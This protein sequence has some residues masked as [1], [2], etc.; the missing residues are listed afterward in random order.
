MKDLIVRSQC[1]IQKLIRMVI[2]FKYQIVL[3]KW[4]Q[5]TKQKLK[6]ITKP[7]FFT[8]ED[9][10]TGKMTV[11]ID[12]ETTQHPKNEEFYEDF[13]KIVQGDYNN[14]CNVLLAREKEKKEFKDKSRKKFEDDDRMETNGDIDAKDHNIFSFVSLIKPKRFI[15]NYADSLK[16]YKKYIIFFSM[17]FY[18][19][20]PLF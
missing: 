14:W 8:F 1:L 10:E 7:E 19:T 6:K 15:P 9:M 5:N 17:Y 18:L 16:Q 20:F 11:K 13:L 2:D 3:L 12:C 4:T